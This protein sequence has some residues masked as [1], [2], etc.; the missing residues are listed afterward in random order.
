MTTIEAIQARHAVR[1]YTDQKIEGQVKDELSAYIDECN[2]EGGLHIQLITDEPRAFSTGIAHYG[3]FRNVKNYISL[4][5]KKSADFDEKIG[6]Y[7]EKIVLKAQQLGLNSCWVAMTYSKGK[8]SYQ[9]GEG[10]KLGMVVSL[11]YGETQ[12]EGHKVKPVEALTS[13]KGEMPDWF[14]KGIA[15]AQLAPTAMNQQKFTFSLNGNK[16]SAKAGLGFYTKVD[17]GIV[18]CHFEIGAGKENFDWE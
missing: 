14:K 12:G 7:G 11:G 1:A 10:E 17:L 15:A 16:V 4:V 2:R 3:K 18:K 9:C 5:G 8:A 13:V 6:F